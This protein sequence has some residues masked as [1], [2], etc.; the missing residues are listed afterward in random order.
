MISI[1]EKELLEELKT[2][3]DI[4]NK[5]K[6]NV[7]NVSINTN[8]VNQ[9]NSIA[10]LAQEAYPQTKFAQNICDGCSNDILKFIKMMVPIYDRLMR[11][12]EVEV[13]DEE[14]KEAEFYKKLFTL[15]DGTHIIEV[16]E[17]PIVGSVEYNAKNVNEVNPFNPIGH[18]NIEEVKESAP[19]K[20]GRKA[21]GK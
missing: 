20:A 19:K 13:I 4:L 14:D 5:I 17:E 11:N 18:D 15:P 21:K 12:D 7:Q 8:T 6:N 2:I 10:K 9:L 3:E 16:D 1:K